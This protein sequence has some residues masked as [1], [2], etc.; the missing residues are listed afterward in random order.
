MAEA[1]ISQSGDPASR[2]SVVET[3]DVAERVEHECREQ[4]VPLKIKDVAMITRIVT[5]M[6]TGRSS[7]RAT[8]AVPSARAGQASG[9][10]T[11][12]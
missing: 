8:T 4:G 10:G 5:L 11:G 6:Q 9:R 3:A 1:A 12:P 7:D 2:G